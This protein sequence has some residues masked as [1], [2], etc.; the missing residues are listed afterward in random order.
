[1]EKN[2]FTGILA[3][4][5]HHLTNKGSYQADSVLYY[6][7]LSINDNADNAWVRIYEYRY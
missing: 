1:M 5:F 7:N 3:R 2:L 6:S 4:S